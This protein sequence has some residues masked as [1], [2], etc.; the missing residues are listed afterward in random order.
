MLLFEDLGLLSLFTYTQMM[1][2]V[3]F[4]HKV[5]LHVRNDNSPVEVSNGWQ[6]WRVALEK[7][8]KTVDFSLHTFQRVNYVYIRSHAMVTTGYLDEKRC[9]GSF[10]ASVVRGFGVLFCFG[11]LLNNRAFRW[12][13]SSTFPK[14]KQ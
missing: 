10:I 4:V 11:V 5:D 1:L 12:R 7:M 9:E 13:L 6:A 8:M 2:V 14:K 3:S